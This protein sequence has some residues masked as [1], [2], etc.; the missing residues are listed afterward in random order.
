VIA[1]AL[2]LTAIT[3]G[4]VNGMAASNKRVACQTNLVQIY[5]A[6]RLYAADE[7]GYFPFYDGSGS[8]IGLWSLYTYPR[9]G[10]PGQL[11]LVGGTTPLDRYLRSAKSLHCPNDYANLNLYQDTDRTTLN[12]AYLSYQVL[13]TASLD[14]SGNPQ[15]T[16]L[17]TRT[18]AGSRQLLPTGERPP[19]DSTVVTWCK[20]HRTGMGGR[21]YDNVLFYDGTVQYLPRQEVPGSMDGASCVGQALSATCVNGWQRTPKAPS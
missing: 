13:D 17:S 12:P 9:S 7:G 18:G 10:F 5:Q 14:G 2:I 8:T 19:A 15:H 21:N 11:A 3:V 1:I 16:Y 4:G 20:W 6:G